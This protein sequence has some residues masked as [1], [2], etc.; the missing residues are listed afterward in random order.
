[1]RCKAPELCRIAQLSVM[2]YTSRNDLTGRPDEPDDASD[3]GRP[4]TE[5]E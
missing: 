4:G 2:D 3:R 1:V 5:Q